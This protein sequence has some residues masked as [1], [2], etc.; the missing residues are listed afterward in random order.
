MHAAGYVK[1]DL[2]LREL[3]NR[4]LLLKMGV[5][6]EV[7]IIAWLSGWPEHKAWESTDIN[8]QSY[9]AWRYFRMLAEN[10]YH[11]QSTVALLPST[12]AVFGQKLD[13][14]M[15][16]YDLTITCQTL[17]VRVNKNWHIRQIQRNTR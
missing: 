14:E 17:D 1:P 7:S 5:T 12:Y 13:A 16:C 2:G 11:Q 8:L 3:S 10:E 4:A 9:A 6:D 15:N